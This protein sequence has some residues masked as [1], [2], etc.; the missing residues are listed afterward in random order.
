MKVTGFI[1]AAC[2][3]VSCSGASKADMPKWRWQ[4]PEK[5]E[6]PVVVEPHPAITALGWTNVTSDYVAVPEGM[7]LFLRMKK[8]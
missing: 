4:D 6:P 1:L 2:L 8:D 3:L 5:P 7:L